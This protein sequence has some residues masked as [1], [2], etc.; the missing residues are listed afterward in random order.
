LVTV[1]IT[2]VNQPPVANPVHVITDEDTPCDIDVLANDTDP[3][4][5][6]IFL[7]DFTRPENGLLTKTKNNV[8]HY[9]P[10][11]NFF[12]SDSFN[13]TIAD[14][15]G[16]TNQ[17]TVSIIVKP[18]NHPPVAQD[19]SF[20]LNR[21]SSV[22]VAFQAV[23]PDDTVLTFS[24]VDGPKHGTLWNYPTVATYYPT[25]GFSG[26]DS[27]TYLANDGKVDGPIATVTFIVLDVNNPPVAEDQSIL[28]KVNQTAPVHLSAT[29][30]DDD[31]LTYTVIALP[32]H[33][34]LSGSGTNYLYQPSPGYLGQDEFTFQAFDGKDVSQPAKVSITVTD[35]N[36]PPTAQD[37]TV[38]VLVNTPTNIT[39]QATDQESDPLSFHVMTRPSHGKL[40]GKGQVLLYSPDT[41]FAGSDRFTFKAND[42]EFDS[43]AGTVTLSVAPANHPP[44][45]TNQ[46]VSVLVNTPTA[47]PLAVQD[48][49]GD[50]LHCPILKGPQHGLLFGLGTNFTY[51]PKPGFV[52]NDTFTYKAW[53]GQIYSLQA[54]VSIQ[55]TA[56]PP[57]GGL[58]FSSVQ[59][60]ANG[61]VRLVLETPGNQAAEVMVSTDLIN[62]S[63]LASPLPGGGK[64]T[65]LDTNAS[66]FP[67]RFYRARQALPRSP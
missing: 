22:T 59:A 6:P 47:I 65:I 23:D 67:R 16:A 18:V 5:D 58:T 61:Q 30:L 13:Y 33:G 52:G 15:H 53:D 56:T 26:T 60:L 24:V 54:T 48:P 21:N 41:Y 9:L 2:P 37:F 63:P 64:T 36:T 27:F 10:K 7:V 4:N 14:S 66:T 43:N 28:T 62:W 42:G 8:F 34:S 39:L 51:S 57:A 46:Q 19:Q 20:T 50:V 12:G 32:K 55:V 29:D 38:Q 49:D 11:T 44:V 17:G 45:T 1:D 31:P 35:K 25:H 40:T 3:E